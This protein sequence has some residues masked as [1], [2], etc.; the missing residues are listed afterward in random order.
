MP[1]LNFVLTKHGGGLAIT[2][3]PR[4]KLRC[5]YPFIIFPGEE[6][7]FSVILHRDKWN[8]YK[9][10]RRYIRRY[11]NYIVQKREKID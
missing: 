1:L 2:G 9:Y 3:I 7:H 8:V 11:E 5:L 6:K 10:K 4:K